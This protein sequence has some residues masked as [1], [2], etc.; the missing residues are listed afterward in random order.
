MGKSNVAV[1]LTLVA[2]LGA[3]GFAAERSKSRGRSRTDQSDDR[4]ERDDRDD[5]RH[6]GEMEILFADADTGLVNLI[7]FGRNFGDEAPTVSLGGKPLVV[8]SSWDPPARDGKAGS[9]IRPIC[10]W[11]RR[12]RTARSSRAAGSAWTNWAA[13]CGRP[14]RTDRS[15]W[16]S[17]THG[18][19][20]TDRSH[21][22]CWT[23]RSSGTDRSHWT[24]W[25]DW[26]RG[27]SGTRGTA[28]AAGPARS[29]GTCRAGGDRHGSQPC[30]E[31]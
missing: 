1:A 28:G 24:C 30:I 29:S 31:L 7:I 14:P 17:W 5:R 23:R 15:H 3:D 10:G 9:R 8:Q 22:T 25:A 11:H 2:L 27:S 6:R 20:R 16:T 4:E 26:A 19:P 13:G 18:T 21:W 12:G